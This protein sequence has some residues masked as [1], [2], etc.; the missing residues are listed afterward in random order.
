MARLL[1]GVSG[2]IAAYKA[3]ETAR[4][5]VKAGHA[6]RVVQ[7]PTAPE[8]TEAEIFTYMSAVGGAGVTT[9]AIQTALLLLNAGQKTRPATC[10]VDL[11]FQHGACADYL[12]LEPRLVSNSVEAMKAFAQLSRGVC[13]QF[14]Q[15]GKAAIP[16]G[17]M[18]ALPL[19]DPPL[20]QAKLFLATRRGRV[21]PIA[22]ATFVEQLKDTLA[23]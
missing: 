14:R 20:L 4:L 13:F 8:Q 23:A 2:G 10:L 18:I 1:L 5:A 22:A 7:T 19:I 12:D 17:D 9:L 11:D 16:P 15:P 21:L 6:V 3:V